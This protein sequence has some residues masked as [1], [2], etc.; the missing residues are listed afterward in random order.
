MIRKEENEKINHIEM[1]KKIA[2]KN[3]KIKA[4]GGNTN[5]KNNQNGVLDN[6]A[7]DDNGKPM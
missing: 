3:A 4:L 7:F 6:V 5:A 1:I 2:A